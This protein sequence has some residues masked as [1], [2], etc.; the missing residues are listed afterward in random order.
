LCRG[1][2]EIHDLRAC[3]FTLAKARDAAEQQAIRLRTAGEALHLAVTQLLIEQYHEEST[4]E[5]RAA[6]LRAVARVGD[7]QVAWK[8]ALA[9]KP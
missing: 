2:H 1:S 5:T 6:Y 3:L 8:E 7:V 4:A 9:W